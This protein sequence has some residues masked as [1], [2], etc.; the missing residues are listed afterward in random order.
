[1]N[2][3]LKLSLISICVHCTLY[4]PQ[5]A[6]ASSL[7]E[8]LSLAREYHNEIDVTSYWYSEKLDGIRAIWTGNELLTRKGYKI[9]TPD[10]FTAHLPDQVIE[11]ELWAG[12]GNFHLVQAT[13]L[14]TSPIES[15][16]RNIR[17]MLFDLPNSKQRYQQRY[18]ILKGLTNN[19]LPSHIEV[20]P[21]Y[22][23]ESPQ[24]IAEDLQALDRVK[25]EG[26]MLRDPNA[27]YHHGRNKSVLKLKKHQ[28][29]EA[30]VIGYKA[31]K[32]KYAGLTG[33]LLVRNADGKTFYIGSGLT[34][35]LRINPPALGEVITYQFNGLTSS[36]IPRFARYLRVVPN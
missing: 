30:M 6:T 21:Q 1:M 3:L 19:V 31:G 5:A 29:A 4:S 24:Q 9:I 35:N 8:S 26:L 36:G 20:I 15:A 16:W 13:V 25:A 27:L 10:W 32:G 14:K 11:G 18:A 17:F 34:D 2:N 12:R 23:V 7:E 33:A 28:D 22:P